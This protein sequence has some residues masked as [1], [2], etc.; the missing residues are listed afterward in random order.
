MHDT[1]SSHANRRE[2]TTP[3]PG[4]GRGE[5]VSSM[6]NRINRCIEETTA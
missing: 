6:S 1:R 2:G 3:V 5:P 4:N